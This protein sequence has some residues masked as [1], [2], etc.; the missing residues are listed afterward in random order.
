MLVTGVQAGNDVDGNVSFSFNDELSMPFPV[1][2]DATVVRNALE[3]VLARGDS[4]TSV[5]RV[6]KG[7]LAVQP[8]VVLTITFAEAAG[9]LPQLRLV[10][11]QPLT[12]AG[13]AIAFRTIQNGSRPF[14]WTFALSYHEI[15]TPP[16]P[17]NVSAEDMATAMSYMNAVPIEGVSVS[18]TPTVPVNGL[19]P[20][21]NGGI[22][23]FTWTLTFPIG[24]Q[25][26]AE[27]VGVEYVDTLTGPPSMTIAATMVAV[28]TSRL[29]G[30]FKLAYGGQSTGD[31]DVEADAKTL[32]TAVETDLGLGSVKVSRINAGAANS[33]VWDVTF[34]SL[35]A[36]VT[37]P[38][39]LATTSLSIT[40]ANAVV[41][42]SVAEPGSRAEVQ[43]LSIYGAATQPSAS[44][45]LSWN[46]QQSTAT[47]NAAMTASQLADVLLT[48][49]GIDRALVVERSS[50]F[51]GV[52]YT[53]FVLF[54][55]VDS[56]T[57]PQLLVDFVG[58][59][60]P[61][62]VTV[63]I[64]KYA[65]TIASL[66]GSF[67]LQ[68]GETC[69]E[70]TIGAYCTPSR[71]SAL[72]FNVAESILASELWA[73]LD[74][75]NLPLVLV[76]RGPRDVANR[77]YS[78]LVT[79][80]F[81][82]FR[83]IELLSIDT[84]GLSG[85]S[86]TTSVD[87]VR[88]GDEAGGGGVQVAVEV[89]ANRQDY[90]RSG[91]VYRYAAAPRVFSIVPSHG[92][93]QGGTEVVLRGV[94]FANSSALHCRFSA[95]DTSAVRLT[96]A[97]YLN[98]THATCIAPSGLEK[99]DVTLELATHHHRQ[100][101]TV[102]ET[103][104]SAITSLGVP[105]TYDETPVF[106]SVF[107][108]MGPVVGNFS[109]R[110]TGGPFKRTHE[111]R[112]KF[113]DGV[114]AAATVVAAQW[115]SFDELECWAPP[116]KQAGVVALRVSLNAQDYFDTR[117]AFTY[118]VEQGLRRISPVFGPAT[119]AGTRVMVEGVSFVNSSLLS[120]RFGHMV[121]PAEFLS[122]TAIVCL[123]PPLSAHSG[124][125]HAVPLSEHRNALPDP[126]TDSV[127][128][129]P[130]AHYFPQY[131]SRLVGVEVSNN[132]QEFSLSGVNFLYY[133][134]EQLD[135]IHPTAAYDSG[136]LFLF[137]L[138]RSF[139]NSTALACRVGNH[140]VR[141]VF[142]SPQ[143]VLCPVSGASVDSGG[144]NARDDGT[145]TSEGHNTLVD[146]SNNGVDFTTS[147]LVFNYRG[148]CPTGFYCPRVLAGDKVAC[149][150]G[151]FCAGTGN[152]NFTLCPPGTFQPKLAQPACRR[153]P[154]G[155]HCPHAGMHV[156]RVCPAGFV[157][158]VTG[159]QQA[160]Q[161]C[162][163]GHFCMEST[164]T[165]A[166]TCTPLKSSFVSTDTTTG[167][168]G[169]ATAVELAGELP[170]TLQRQTLRQ[171]QQQRRQASATVAGRRSGCWRNETS[172]FGLQLSSQPS[173]FWM[174]RRSLPLAPGSLFTPIRGRFCLDDACVRLSDSD[175]L[176]VDNE[177]LEDDLGD[178]QLPALRQP[179]PCP[180][181][182]YCHAG[183]AARD[184]LMKNFSTAQPCFESMYCPE[185][186]A[187][188]RGAGECAP[189]FYCPFGTRLT[190][191]AGSYCPVSGL[192]A[193]LGCPPGT[194]NGQIGQER[195][196]PCPV[197]FL[198]PGFHRIMPALCPAGFV[199]S[200]TGLS[201]PNLL[202]PSGLY[203][204][205]GTA[206]ADPFRNDTRLRPY[207]C[208]P[209]TYCLRGVMADEVRTGDY[210]Y[211]QNCTEGFYCE[212]GSSSPKGS[213][214]CPR[215]FTCLSGTAV[216]IP[217]PKRT[218]AELEGSVQSAQCAPGY[219]A[220]T[221]ESTSCIPCPPGTSCED[222]GTK[223]A[224]ACPPGSY[225]GILA[226]DGVSC[227]ACPQGIWSKNWELRG[228]DEC[229]T[230]PPG[231]VCPID[232]ITD[233]C[234]PS[235]LPQLYE[236]VS[237]NNATLSYS[238]CLDRGSAYFFGVLLEPWI[239]AQGR[240]P[241]LLPSR[242]YGKCYKNAQ[243]LGSVLY[244]RLADYHG[245]LYELTESG[246]GVPHQ[247]YGDSAQY[248][249][250][251]LFARGALAIDLSVSQPFDPARNCT[252]GFYHEGQWF[253][254]TC[255]ADVFCSLVSASSSTLATKAVAQAQPCPEGYVCD[256]STTADTALSILCPGGY[257]CA[258]GSTPDLTLE[259]PQGQLNELCPASKVCAKGTAES[260]KS[261]TSCPAGYF[262]PTGT[263]NPY[264]GAVADDAL[265][266]GLSTIDANPFAGRMYTK[267]IGDGD[268]RIVSD[269]D[270]R[271]FAGADSDLNTR[272]HL[273]PSPTNSSRKVVKKRATTYDTKCARDHKWRMVELALR[274]QECDCIKQTKVMRRV[275][276]MWKCTVAPSSAALTVYD[277]DSYGGWEIRGPA[278]NSAR[279]CTFT[280]SGSTVDLST[281]LT[282][283]DT[284]EGIGFQ[285]AW[286][287]T[288]R[289]LS[290]AALKSFV[291]SEFDAQVSEIP[292]TRVSVDP[293]MF[294]LHHAVTLVDA[295]G[296]ETPNVAG[297]VP[298]SNDAQL[299][300]LDACACANM[301]KCPNGTTST[302]GTDDIY[303]CVK[304][305]TE[306]L[307]RISLLSTDSERVINS[308][309]YVELSGTGEGVGSLVLEPYEVA[310]ITVNATDLPRN[311][312]YKDHYQVS[313]Y[314]NCKPCP[315][316]YTCDYLA[317]SSSGMCKYPN[318][319]N[320]TSA[321]LLAECMAEYD[322]EALCSSQP[323]Y[324]EQRVVVESATNSTTLFPSC[325][326][327]ERTRMPFYFEDA[328][329]PTLGF[330]DS[331]HALVQFT[332]TAVARTELTVV[333]ELLHG[334]YVQDFS[335]GFTP[336]RFDLF[337]F[338]PGRADYSP[339][340]PST[341]SFLA[342]MPQSTYDG[343]MLPLNL[344]EVG[345]RV[346]GTLTYEK[347][348]VT[349]VLLDHN[350][351]VLVGGPDLPSKHG[352]IRDTQQNAIL[353][354]N[355]T[356]VTLTALSSSSSGSS[357][358]NE[359]S[360]TIV[361][362]TNYFGLVQDVD[363]LSSVQRSDTWWSE[364]LDGA[365]LLVL[366][367]LP[368]SSSC[369][370]FGST[371][372]LAKLVKSHP[373][374]SLVSYEETIEVNQYPWNKKMTPHADSCLIEYTVEVASS[375]GDASVSSYVKLERGIN[376][377]CTYEENLEGGAEKARWYEAATDTVLFYLSRDPVNA[378]DFVAQPDDAEN[379]PWGRASAF[380]AFVNTD[381]LVPVTGEPLRPLTLMLSM[382][383]LCLSQSALARGPRWLCRARCT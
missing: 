146:V 235:D 108:S 316:R 91:V 47:A 360:A 256:Q 6:D 195:C 295:F 50:S 13:A 27:V 133:A 18:R 345:V 220:P 98:S 32:Q 123:S 73:L 145:R 365:D 319:D 266:R 173:R 289:F 376:M 193:P 90:S 367:Y 332:I 37:P 135:A 2:A 39:L 212:L 311:L 74:D 329:S 150:R 131:A 204:L 85:A 324:C 320:S 22:S 97:T 217:T 87:R 80:P 230:C 334:L 99:G 34:Q 284:T 102:E 152:A 78:W 298:G 66:S 304:T 281:L 113:G 364:Q 340:T 255:E 1:H 48:I 189:G 143:L 41:A 25:Y 107:P 258:P 44:F 43:T 371:M 308:T 374:C 209:G 246:A 382:L 222:D 297:F 285:T 238:E 7:V 59:L 171:Q 243:P 292:S 51:V 206:T 187:S 69:S 170:P 348:V 56:S 254:G 203:C 139:I 321:R 118:Y 262:C 359:T 14:D 261:R 251:N 381:Q 286:T 20:S 5:V 291:E 269:H 71:T 327:C 141:A 156:P 26:P 72:P 174:E 242:D 357:S 215:G 232:G 236:P 176:R 179:I 36:A 198:C 274:R 45:T 275:F 100:S 160:Q 270:M 196:T 17:W 310:V 106:A 263:A 40:G 290:Y 378:D 149:P 16:L 272:F 21:A 64:V 315:P 159:I 349:N 60:T 162:P 116:A 93:L 42:V 11:Q 244:Q 322:D 65:S 358:S 115:I 177:E 138:G 368:F 188:P 68:L 144:A 89:S 239:D 221:I 53:W 353:E 247:G 158:D 31:L 129:F 344:P 186:S 101:Q 305:G 30:T 136:E 197:G 70:L 28:E 15:C 318:G 259:A 147:G 63:S 227:L 293:F 184:E 83:P 372:S 355:S 271:C 330:P 8:G 121:V 253:P 363:P 23:G 178:L 109:V 229:I 57:S 265:R 75:A 199:C 245:P 233:P 10:T 140:V 181:G 283:S 224:A 191:P 273:V 172:D 333:V 112:C 328:S 169:L 309:D 280:T 154:V 303:D 383:T 58:G 132:Q 55:G 104:S 192:L 82:A 231:A 288:T 180:A 250:P 35:D 234:A 111:L 370:G 168:T 352:F 153:C 88:K 29:T 3:E 337:V 77:D 260:Q 114:E 331:K 119:A 127:L 267:Y 380:Q 183:T 369:R 202:C 346:N 24:T 46:N 161:P 61:S 377:S 356:T 128:L 302:A 323:F 299:L 134:D 120:C 317:T 379:Q 314:E 306:V 12:G 142:V 294:D 210:R 182:S 264:I 110:V 67:K 218:F 125:L 105:F 249:A 354:S 228:I 241:H 62:G 157:C 38:S 96:A 200:K 307:Q 278:V 33:A 312:T 248:P 49:P 122:S 300:R 219:Y 54:P 336:D 137:A 287:E 347:Q 155:F 4:G 165:T 375:S 313:V 296:D 76:F 190:C 341:R 214:L 167:G 223:E 362:P 257:V 81:V 194:F 343:L 350:S 148:Q 366:P 79:F 342:F 276:Q 207:P 279:Q 163:E 185:G 213:G 19:T 94:N 361:S 124:G 335:D 151:A 326:A 208:K 175:N 126:V 84:S 268:V 103:V 211:P 164:A 95:A 351:D 338:T 237:E 9:D 86:L 117:V 325:C 92:P 205:N 52:G 282:A 301:L 252:K 166:I 226:A 373:D 130:T 216:P 201:S 225:R 240:G 339:A 277:P